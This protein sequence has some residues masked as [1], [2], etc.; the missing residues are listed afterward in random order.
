MCSCTCR[1][2]L[3]V[4]YTHLTGT[5]IHRLFRSALFGGLGQHMIGLSSC[6]YRC[7]YPDRMEEHKSL[8]GT[9]PVLPQPVE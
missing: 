5:D 6:R 7:R 9:C 1:L 2:V 4:V 3:V 8:Q